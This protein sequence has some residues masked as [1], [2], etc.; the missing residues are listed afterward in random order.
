M[1]PAA[2]FLPARSN[3]CAMAGGGLCANQC[4]VTREAGNGRLAFSWHCPASVPAPMESAATC[5]QA[6]KHTWPIGRGWGSCHRFLHVGRAAFCAPMQLQLPSFGVV[7]A[8]K[9]QAAAKL[10]WACC[11]ALLPTGT[12][13]AHAPHQARACTR[14]WTGSQTTLPT[15]SNCCALA[16]AQTGPASQ[17]LHLS[18]ADAVSTAPFSCCSCSALQCGPADWEGWVISCKPHSWL[19][20]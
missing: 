18:W 10:D 12:S 3:V 7:S 20:L 8:A 13:R 9:V 14:A 19:I 16:Y 5:M 4:A 11:H 1:S 17:A 6:Q 15:P 2:V